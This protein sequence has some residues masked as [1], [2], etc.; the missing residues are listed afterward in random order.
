MARCPP[1]LLIFTL[2]TILA[3]AAAFALLPAAK[4]PRLAGKQDHRRLPV[5]PAHGT[6]RCA[7]ASLIREKVLKNKEVVEY[8]V[9]PAGA[10]EPFTVRE[11]PA[12]L[13]ISGSGAGGGAL[14]PV[15]SERKFLVPGVGEVRTLELD[16][17]E[18]G[19]GSTV[20]DSGIALA[21][22]LTSESSPFAED[23]NGKRVLELGCGP[24]LPG[25]TAALAFPDAEV[26]LTDYNP[27]I[28]RSLQRLGVDNVEA[29]P[30]DW[31]DSLRPGGLAQAL[32]GRG[33]YDLCIAADCIYHSIPS[34]F[35]ATALELLDRN[36]NLRL[37]VISQA[38]RQGLPLVVERLKALSA[39]D[40]QQPGGDASE[41]E[42]PASGV[43]G[44]ASG[45]EGPAS[46]WAGPAS[47][48]SR[49]VTVTELSF[50][51]PVPGPGGEIR[52]EGGEVVERRLV[53][54]EVSR[55]GGG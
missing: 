7:S 40:K 28:A 3:H 43:D 49:D 35:T 31:N 26:H 15:T 37:I 6:W 48:G 22:L 42:E 2:A 27:A 41:E 14:G 45:S 55:V 12:T 30:L 13:D 51:A 53:A 36:P 9:C 50:A 18:A 1:P 17:E 44:P 10:P 38:D 46:G 20:W 5:G 32:A 25:L 29:F 19:L 47:G 52:G 34:A 16:P 24:A 54:L 4:L 33:D 39:S 8:T 11:V 21:A 23:L